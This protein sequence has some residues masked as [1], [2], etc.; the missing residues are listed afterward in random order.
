MDS[1]GTTYFTPPTF[2]ADTLNDINLYLSNSIKNNN[3]IKNFEANEKFYKWENVISNH[4]FSD[5]IV[6]NITSFFLKKIA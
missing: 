6:K 3:R 2:I 1:S 5:A 4:D